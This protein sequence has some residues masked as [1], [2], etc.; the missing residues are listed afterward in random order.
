MTSSDP[1]PDVI[2]SLYVDDQLSPDERAEAEAD[3]GFAARVDALGSVRSALGTLDDGDAPPP[4]VRK[5]QIAAAV[6]AYVPVPPTEP[7]TVPATPTPDPSGGRWRWPT[8]LAPV[9][10]TFALAVIAVA[11]ITAL[12][13][14][15]AD[16]TTDSL[17]AVAADLSE[18]S[19]A[20]TAA[21]ESMAD[22]AMA[23]DAME[24]E[25]MEMADSDSEE[26]SDEES[27]EDSE[28]LA[29]GDIELIAEPFA[30][31]GV[32]DPDALLEESLGLLD[33]EGGISWMTP[34]CPTSEPDRIPVFIRLG[35]V[36][37]EPA[38]FVI[39]EG[40]AGLEADLYDQT[41]CEL[42]AR[43]SGS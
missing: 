10:L 36:D 2:A 4:S 28:D 43:S 32:P 14:G 33:H 13:Q 9:G 25:S 39:L 31:A 22:D 8:W 11:G 34:D 24:D 21:A 18:Q 35:T 41:T 42:L 15:S 12:N 30:V 5:P 38:Q 26:D 37:E 19:T 40:P 6:A 3:P 16:D 29:S 7:A 1:N 27:G 17:D 23:D 20:T